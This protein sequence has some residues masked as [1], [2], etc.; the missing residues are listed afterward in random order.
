MRAVEALSRNLQTPVLSG[1]HSWR[2]RDQLRNEAVLVE[3]GGKKYGSAKQRLVPFGER[4]PWSEALPFLRRLAPSPAVSPGTGVNPLPLAISGTA[5][6]G[7]ASSGTAASGTKIAT[8]KL[9]TVVCFESCFRYPARALRRSGA[10]M[11]FVLTNDEWFH[12]TNAP[13]EHAAMLTVRA[14]ENSVS[15]A[16]AA[17]GGYTFAVDPRGRFMVDV[18]HSFGMPG[19]VEVVLPLP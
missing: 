3:P 9:G 19:T 12:G 4:A 7:T 1:M 14:V 13:W 11:L 17:N 8:A 18:K 10:Q 6:S 2:G 15:L 16:Q 5:A